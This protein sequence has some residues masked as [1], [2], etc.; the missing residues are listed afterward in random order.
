MAIAGQELARP[1]HRFFHVKSSL[2]ANLIGLKPYRSRR[3]KVT[4]AQAVLM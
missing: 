1:K 3:G 4:R 2:L